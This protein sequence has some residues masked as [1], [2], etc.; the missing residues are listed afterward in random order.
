MSRSNICRGL[1]FTLALLV[2][3]SAAVCVAAP[4]PSP[5]TALQLKPT[6]P[7]IEY[8][9][10]QSPEQC[11]V[12]IERYNKSSSGWVV[13]DPAGLVLRRFVDT[14]DDGFVDQYRYY[15]DGVE[16]YRE[17]DTNF[18]KQ[19]DQMRWFNTAGTRWGLDKNEDGKIETWK[20]LSPEEAA[21]EAA[22]ALINNDQRLL[23]SLTLSN[24]DVTQLGMKGQIVETIRKNL[25]DVG[26]QLDKIA[27]SKVFTS[28][29]KWLQF[30]GTVP[31][32]I[33][34][35]QIG[36]R[37]EIHAHQNSMMLIDNGGKATLVQLGTLIRVGDAWKLTR[38]PQPIEGNAVQV[39]EDALF[40]PTLANIPA[41]NP[42]AAGANFSAKSQKLI[43]ELQ[44]ID[45]KTPGPMASRDAWKDYNKER[46]DILLK[47]V[48]AAE[49]VEEREQWVKQIADGIAAGV[50]SDTY[51]N[52]IEQLKSMLDDVEKKTPQ[53]PLVAY[54]TY[55]IMTA[56]YTT[57]LRKVSSD[58]T[59]EVQEAW[60]KSLE[61]FIK[62]FP[63]NDDA[64]EAM[65]QLG[66]AYEFAN[67]MKD[68]RT[69]YKELVKTSPASPPG[70]RAAGALRRLDS[71]GEQFNLKGET[72]AGQPFDIASIKDK[73]VVVIYWAN[74]SEPLVK[75]LPKLRAYDAQYRDRGLRFV[76]VSVDATKEDAQAWIAENKIDWT[77]VYEKGGLEGSPLSADY[78]IILLPT[79]FVLDKEGKVVYRG[80]AAAELEP[81]LEDL[82]K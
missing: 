21:R 5:K 30:H 13:T 79:I 34:A 50:Q 35:E 43:D 45:K 2:L 53:S 44:A 61:G 6:Q 52:G 31:S 40:A 48:G 57:R 66:S 69:W 59:N 55:R 20:I 29:S 16:V 36:S 60:L 7:D 38:V 8:D 33:P 22:K 81:V 54:I 68:A 76:G 26:S 75:D 11:K 32:T 24:E 70:L 23:N 77:Q 46:T 3:C 72:L 10:P 27:D 25:S 49:N 39:A 58:K 63:K 78:G 41:N 71:K 15:H 56:D 51:P 74:W 18:N 12:T 67:K 82:F 28:K 42:A 47:L 9:I 4:P 62:K 37:D 64:P 80:A 1:D 14:N 19:V 73:V 17:L 65:F